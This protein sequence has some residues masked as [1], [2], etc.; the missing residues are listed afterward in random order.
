[1]SKRLRQ[2]VKKLQFEYNWTVE[3]V[4]QSVGYS[5]VHLTREMKKDDSTE[6]EKVF[7]VKYGDM[8]QNVS[9][10]ELVTP[11]LIINKLTDQNRTLIDNNKT[12]TDNNKAL[13]DLHKEFIE[14]IFSSLENN[15]SIE[16]LVR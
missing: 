3:K 10:Q 5:R 13:V 15:A 6:I 12:L 4:A 7:E 8:I 2:I 11:L 16:P 9:Q 14:K 1:M